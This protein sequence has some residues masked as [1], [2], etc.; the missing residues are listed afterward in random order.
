LAR[1]AEA[2]KTRVEIAEEAE[3]TQSQISQIEKQENPLLATVRRYV[4]AV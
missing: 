3:M 1:R 4:R 2:S